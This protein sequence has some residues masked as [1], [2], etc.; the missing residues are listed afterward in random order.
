MEV[1]QSAD[2]DTK[3]GGVLEVACWAKVSVEAPAEVV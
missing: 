3:A 2:A 1:V